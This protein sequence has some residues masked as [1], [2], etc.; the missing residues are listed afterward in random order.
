MEGL[1]EARVLG[2]SDR[3]DFGAQKRRTVGSPG[4]IEGIGQ[5]EAGRVGVRF[6]QNRAEAGSFH[7][8]TN[9][10]RRRGRLPGAAASCSN[11][12][13]GSRHVHR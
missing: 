13:R 10:R 3:R 6:V 5:A 8:A 7:G 9:T 2:S 12:T 1:A 11:G 4:V